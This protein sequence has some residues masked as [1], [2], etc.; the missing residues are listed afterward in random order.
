MADMFE[1]GCS[2]GACRYVASGP[3]LNVRV[4]HCR[5]CQKAVGAAFNARALFP[6]AAVRLSGPIGR[7]A[8]SDDVT[9]GYCTACGT[10]LFSERASLA[11]LGLT[12]GS[13]DQPDRLPPTE[14]IW[15]ERIHAWLVLSE[16][17]A[18][19]AGAAPI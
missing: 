5:K 15:V 6:K 11:A 9:R 7:A 2:C 14:H 12:L 16:G 17:V 3:A 13:L 10:S 4:C 8:S 19:Q 18:L 1:G